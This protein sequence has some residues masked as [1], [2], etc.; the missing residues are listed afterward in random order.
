MPETQASQRLPGILADIV[1]TKTAE[2]AELRPRAKELERAA[3]VAEPPRDFAGALA[4]P[5]HVA[6]IAEC[7]RR[8]PGAGEIRPGLDPRPSRRDTRARVRPR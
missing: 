1:R 8:S 4:R 5:D 3:E 2:L 6:L 7:K